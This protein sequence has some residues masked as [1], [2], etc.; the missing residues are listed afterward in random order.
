M[1]TGIRLISYH[2]LSQ[3]PASATDAG[4]RDARVVIGVDRL[5]EVNR[6]L[7]LLTE[8]FAARVA[9]HL[10]QEEAS[11]ALWHVVVRRTV[12]VQHLPYNTTA[13]SQSL[14]AGSQQEAT[15]SQSQ[16]CPLVPVP[17]S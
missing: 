11:V 13:A 16:V 7:E 17:L 9:R 3:V 12:L 15:P 14:H 5:A 8:H 6:V 4:Q 10:E 1:I 2:H